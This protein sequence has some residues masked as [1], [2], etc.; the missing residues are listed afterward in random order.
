MRTN[1]PPDEEKVSAAAKD[2]QEKLTY[3]EEHFLDKGPYISGEQPTI[4]D[5]MAINE[6]MHPLTGKKHF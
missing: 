1:T 5:I 3:I 6:I 2:L 4:A